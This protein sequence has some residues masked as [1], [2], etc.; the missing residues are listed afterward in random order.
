MLLVVLIP[1]ETHY[2]ANLK[3]CNY[4]ALRKGHINLHN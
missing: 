3:M 2:P 4:G 1:E